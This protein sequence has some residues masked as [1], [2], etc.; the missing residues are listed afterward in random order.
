[1]FGADTAVGQD[2]RT[3]ETQS[4]GWR[5]LRGRF[6][7][8]SGWAF[9]LL[10]LPLVACA[11]AHYDGATFKNDDVAFRIGPPPSA[12]RTL[13]TDE[14]LIAFR[15]D[16]SHATIGVNG[17][18]G[19]DGD[20][21]PLRALTQHLFLQFTD[22][23][24][25]EERELML[26]GRA[27]LQTELLAKLDGVP[28]R[29]SVFVLKK[30]GCVYDFVRIADASAGDTGRAEFQTFVESFQTLPRDGQGKGSAP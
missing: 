15:D 20:D 13:Q 3:N 23:N 21:V 29:F 16:P 2:E 1:M 12:W 9:A 17:R 5:G 30:D 10:A 11:G 19:Q 14:A 28:K 27:A 8:G 25:V 22:R 7:S 24:L 6:V 26:D 4:R 18:C